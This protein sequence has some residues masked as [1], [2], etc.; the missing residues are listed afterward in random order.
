ML[1]C[2]KWSILAFF[3]PFW[4]LWY[5]LQYFHEFSFFQISA[6]KKDVNHIKKPLNAFMLY[7]KEMRPVVQAECTL[8]ESAA[9]N[10]ILGRRVRN[11]HFSFTSVHIIQ[12]REG[13]L[14][15]FRV[16]NWN[17]FKLSQVL[18]EFCKEILDLMY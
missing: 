3:E 16:A 5:V 7:M 9:I 1:S 17:I 10:Q 13:L 15:N 4:L 11:V 6:K 8:K 18:N 2:S 12:F 14:W